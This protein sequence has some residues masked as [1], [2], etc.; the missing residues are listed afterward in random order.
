MQTA[1]GGVITNNTLTF[2]LSQPVIL[3]RHRA[4]DQARTVGRIHFRSF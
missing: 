1:T 2:T 4:P 3:A